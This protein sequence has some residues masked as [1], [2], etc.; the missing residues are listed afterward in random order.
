MSPNSQPNLGDQVFTVGYPTPS[1]L[2]SDPKYTNGTV[3]AL[4]GIGND[5]SFLQISVPV[6]P[7]NS[8]GPLVNQNGEVI[9]VVVATADAPAFIRA[10]DSIPQNINLVV[11]SVFASAL[12]TP[13]E[14]A[15]RVWIPRCAM[16]L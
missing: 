11:K 16:G 15:E 5:A 3:S 1:L 13:P 6:Q 7:G 4:P 9:G 14:G 2:G 8:D 12:F 10:T